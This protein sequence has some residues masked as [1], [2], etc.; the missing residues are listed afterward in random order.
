KGDGTFNQT[1]SV[2][3]IGFPSSNFMIQAGDLNG[4]GFA[5]FIFA[6]NVAANSSSILYG[7]GDGTF[8]SG[9]AIPG[10]DFSTPNNNFLTAD[11]NGDG[12]TDLLV[13]RY[14]DTPHFAKIYLSG[15]P[16]PDYLNSI[17]NGIGGQTQIKIGTASCRERV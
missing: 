10:N 17:S 9:G 5:D 7:R 3:L 12:Q 1:T 14:S 13:Y 16:I 6:T 2:P 8:V 15:S 4:D 11:F